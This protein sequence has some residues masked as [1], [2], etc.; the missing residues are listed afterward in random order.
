MQDDEIKTRPSV[1]SQHNVELIPTNLPEFKTVAPPPKGFDPLRATA[2]ELHRHHL[3][4]CPDPRTSKAAAK[5]WR[6]AMSRIRTFVAPQLKPGNRFRR[7]SLGNPAL[8]GKHGTQSG[9]AGIIASEG[10]FTQVWSIF[11]YP[12][13]VAPSGPIAQPVAGGVPN[14]TFN[15][16]IG[17]DGTD[18]SGDVCQA[19]VET[20]LYVQ[21]VSGGI[22]TNTNTYPWI[23]WYPLN[24]IVENFLISPGDTIALLIQYLGVSNNQ[25]QASVQFSNLTT[26][27]AITPI[28]LTAPYGTLQSDNALYQGNTAEWIVEPTA[29]TNQGIYSAIADF[30]DLIFVDAGALSQPGG[31]KGSII[32]A[33]NETQETNIVVN[34]NTV[35]SEITTAALQISYLPTAGPQREPGIEESV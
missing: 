4:H 5:A 9:W 27:V 1:L 18:G 10:S 21:A 28:I 15:A 12:H 2:D 20:D 23:E 24:T 30:G 17:L 35:A 8:I 16:W 7:A 13:V 29:Y 31:S 22:D 32:Q 25:F 3:P 33:S 6:K 19:G 26:G 34:N 11:V 14:Y